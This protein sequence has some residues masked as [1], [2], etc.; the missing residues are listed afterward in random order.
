[1]KGRGG[2]IKNAMKKVRKLVEEKKLKNV[3]RFKVAL[4]STETGYVLDERS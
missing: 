2:I 4:K 3:K 1:M